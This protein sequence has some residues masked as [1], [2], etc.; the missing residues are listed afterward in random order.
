MTETSDMSV[1]IVRRYLRE[2]SD[3]PKVVKADAVEALLYG[4]TVGRG[5]APYTTGSCL[6]SSPGLA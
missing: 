3:Q 1:E 5:P 2:L 4:C 6:A